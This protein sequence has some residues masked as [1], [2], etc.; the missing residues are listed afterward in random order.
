MNSRISIVQRNE[1]IGP[2]QATTNGKATEMVP[3][4]EMVV[5]VKN[6]IDEFK[7]RSR[8]E[9]LVTLTMPLKA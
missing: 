2:K 8:Q 1:T 3:N 9:T 6:W 7:L 5:L 4:R